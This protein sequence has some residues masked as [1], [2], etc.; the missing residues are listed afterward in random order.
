[1]TTTLHRKERLLHEKQEVARGTA[2]EDKDDTGITSELDRDGIARELSFAICNPR[3]EYKTYSGI[4]IRN[5]VD[6]V[7]IEMQDH[8]NWTSSALTGRNSTGED[9]HVVIPGC[10]SV[11]L[12]RER[13]FVAWIKKR[14]VRERQHAVWVIHGCCKHF[15]RHFGIFRDEYE[16]KCNGVQWYYGLAEHMESQDEL[17][18]AVIV[19][20]V[21]VVAAV[22]VAEVLS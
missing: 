20:A 18:V 5:G 11:S 3:L 15:G 19:V 14:I 1:M 4:V 16:G 2:K 17:V 13:L 8:C 6:S 12:M 10:A 21:V 22:V 9:R 7:Q